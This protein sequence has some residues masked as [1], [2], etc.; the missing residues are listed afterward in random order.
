MQRQTQ[1]RLVSASL[2][3]PERCLF[4]RFRRRRPV[5]VFLTAG[6]RAFPLQPIYKKL[7]PLYFPRSEEEERACRPLVPA[8]IGNSE[9]EPIVPERQIRISEKPG[10]LEGEKPHP[11]PYHRPT[12]TITANEFHLLVIPSVTSEIKSFIED[13]EEKMEISQSALNESQE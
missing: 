11:R 4:R 9:G 8:D 2:P 3:S 5:N 10:V 13:I 6:V 7:L 1:K 12:G